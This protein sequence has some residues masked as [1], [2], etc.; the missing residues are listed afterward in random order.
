MSVRVVL[1]GCGRIAGYFHGPIL[2]ALPGAEL[3]AAVDADPDARARATARTPG[4]TRF[5][6]WGPALAT[7]PLDAAVIC[8]PPALHAPA[9]RD[10]LA[11]GLHVYIEK[12][13]ETALADGQAICSAADAAGRLAVTGFN[14]RFHP[15]VEDARARITRGELGEIIAVRSLFTAARRALPGWKRE[16]GLGGGVLADLGSHHFDLIPF[17]TG[18]SFVEGSLTASLTAADEG[19]AASVLGL[20]DSGTQVSMTVSQLTGHST[21][22][23]EILGEK[24]HL[25]VDLSAARPAKLERPPGRL[26]RVHRLAA[27]LGALAPAELLHNPGAEPSFGRALEAFIKATTGAQ[28]ELATARDGLAVIRLVEEAERAAETPAAPLVLEKA[29]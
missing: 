15:L 29:G 28:T 13:L 14:F 8:L 4:V 22:R 20:L 24:G 9:A 6:D 25:N 16:R 7:M 10:A 12:P 21:N 26:A 2:G 27:R 23:L 11:A 1:I 19:E 17:L 5:A 18:T 3:V